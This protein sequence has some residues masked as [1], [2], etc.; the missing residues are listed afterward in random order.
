MAGKPGPKRR[1]TDAERAER[2][3]S[4]NAATQAKIARKGQDIGPIPAVVNWERRNACRTD[5][6]LF[7]KTYLA[8]A[9]HK[10]FCPDHYAALGKAQEAVLRGG[11]FAQA[12]PRADGKSERTKGTATW[13]S[14]YGHRR[15]TLMIGATA[16]AAL[17][18]LDGV[19]F[20]FE[21]AGSI[22]RDEDGDYI[23]FEPGLFPLLFE[24]FPEI[25]FPILSLDGQAN[26]QK[27]QRCGERRTL[28]HWGGKYITLPTVPPGN[29]IDGKTIGIAPGAG[30]R[31]STTGITGR[32]RGFNINGERPS[33]VLPDDVQTDETANSPAG[34]AKIERI[35]AGAVIGLA[36][37]GKKIA[38]IM[39]CT[40]IARG[41]AIDNILSHEKH[42]EWDSSR[43]KMLYAFPKRLE[44]SPDKPDEPS[45]EEYRDIRYGYNPNGIDGEKQRAAEEA[46]LYYLRHAVLLQ[47]GAAVAWSERFAEDELDAL[48]CAMNFYFQD[49]R[50]FFAEYQ[51]EPLPDDVGD[52]KE[53]TAD[54]IAGKLSQV[55]RGI[56]PLDTDTLTA[57]IDVQGN[58]LFY[59]VC[60]WRSNFTGY[61]IDY[62]TYPKQARPYF[63]KADISPTLAHV[64]GKPGEEAQIYAG[65]ETLTQSLLG[66]DWKREHVDG[67]GAVAK[68]DRILVDSGYQTEVV[69]QF[70]R[71]SLYAPLITPSKGEY[72]GEAKRT[73]NKAKPKQGDKPGLE[74]ILHH[75]RENRGVRLLRFNTNYWKTFVMERLA[76]PLFGKDKE[77]RLAGCL[78]LF[79]RD[80]GVHRLF[81]DHL[82]SERRRRVKEDKPDAKEFVE[83]RLKSSNLNNDFF[84]ALVGC[85]VAAA[86]QG[87]AL[88]GVHQASPVNRPERKRRSLAEL[89]AEARRIA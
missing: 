66:T 47:E 50:A 67:E 7:L 28:I 41:D 15:F 83:W 82:T 58:V 10:P 72:I 53:L 38:G 62:G 64:T 8:Y 42:P 88:E 73:I 27:G 33:L 2:K 36:G 78:S 4:S 81:A 29:W 60:A 77:S 24:D 89:K 31:L 45:W 46:T 70:C 20:H 23:G 74:W 75:A 43:T 85:T 19:R 87:V 59:C 65:L 55:P 22:V 9:F 63:T 68:I 12:A 11:L 84:D 39:P 14:L 86:M 1:F 71:R 6:P 37:P 34:N 18:L 54:E 13:A 21:S 32:I 44:R 17:E 40:V 79:G 49:K 57:F 76:V 52:L 56:V 35:L 51:N 25:V 80:A 16:D 5:L 69:Y 30:V 61:V 48:Q 3:R 26:K